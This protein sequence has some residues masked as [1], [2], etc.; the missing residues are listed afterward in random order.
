MVHVAFDELHMKRLGA[1]VHP[2]NAASIRILEKLGFQVDRRDTVMGM[3]SIGFSLAVD[4]PI[5]SPKGRLSH[6]CHAS[7]G[8]SQQ[9][10]NKR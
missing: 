8:K 7:R 6:Y 3:D 4:T 10:A 1:F 5:P 2:K 9:I